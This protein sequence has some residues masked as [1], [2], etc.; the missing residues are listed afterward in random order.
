MRSNRKNTPIE[1]IQTKLKKD[2]TIARYSQGVMIGQWKD[3][4]E[5]VY[6]STEFK[7]NMVLSTIKRGKK[8]LKPEPIMNYNKFMSGVNRHDQMQSYYP[9]SRKT[10]R[11]YKKLAYIL[12]KCY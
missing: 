9:F 1:V 2:E 7:N 6:I 5:V 10:V 11:W 3:K 8:H 12:Y 4:R